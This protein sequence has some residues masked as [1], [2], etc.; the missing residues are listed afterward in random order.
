MLGAEVVKIESS[1]GD[2]FRSYGPFR[3]YDGMSPAFVATN[4]GKKSIVIDLKN[5]DGLEVAKRLIAQSDVVLENFRPGVMS[6]LGLGYETARQL[7]PGLVYC[8]VSGYGQ[9]GSRRDFP[10]IDNIM[11]AVTGMMAANGS[12]GDPPSRVGWPAVDTYTGTLAA[13]AVL[14]A[15]LQRERY[16]DGQYIDV[17][18][19]DASIVMLTSLATPY[20]ITGQ[21]LP[22]TGDIGYSGSPTSGMYSTRDGGLLSLGVV[23]NNHFALLCQAIGRPELVTDH[24]FATPPARAHSQHAPVL[25][26]IVAGAIVERDGAEWERELSMLGVPCGLVRNIAEA[27][28]LEGLENRDLFV[29]ITAPA[30]LRGSFVNAG[31]TFAHDGPGVTAAVPRL[32]EHTR[33]ILDALGYS[34]AKIEQLLASG[35]AGVPDARSVGKRL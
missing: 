26:A 11:Q 25:K 33:E 9:Q 21:Q 7:R 8:S 20:L 24:R 18:M 13:L 12:E 27:C 29:P 2:H 19:F 15:L 1:R 34:T 30:A 6:R 14:A 31:F 4:V 23:Q 17:A 5:D 32:G 22:R 16:G 10:A 28:G 35:A 3:E